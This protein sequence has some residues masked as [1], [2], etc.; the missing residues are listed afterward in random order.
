M[1][2]ISCNE[3]LL[4]LAAFEATYHSSRTPISPDMVP[5]IIDFG[6]SITISPYLIDFVDNI[7][8]VQDIAIQGIASGLQVEAIGD[9][10]YTFCNDSGA[11]QTM[12][13]TGALYVPK[14]TARLLCPRQLGKSTGL[15]QDGFQSLSDKGILTYQG[16]QTTVSYEPLSQLPIRVN[17][18]GCWTGIPGR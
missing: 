16:Q 17:R 10:S 3:T 14:C 7:H 18:N 11:S 5:L 15:P 2:S 1:P 13:I 12:K 6:A 8:P 4:L 9:L